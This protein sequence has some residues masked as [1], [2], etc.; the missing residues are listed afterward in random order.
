MPDGS[1]RKF[2]VEDRGGAI[3]AGHLDIYV[4]HSN[5]DEAIRF[6]RQRL[7]AKIYENGDD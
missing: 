7:R 1:I 5:R 3:T 6:G 2:I 4:G